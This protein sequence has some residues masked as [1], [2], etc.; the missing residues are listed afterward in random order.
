MITASVV[1]VRNNASL[2]RNIIGTLKKD[3]KVK[4][5]TKIGDWWSIYYGQHGGFVSAEYINNK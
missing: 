5:S 1:N 3:D 4:L 2:D